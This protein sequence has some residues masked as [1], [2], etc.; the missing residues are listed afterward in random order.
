MPD[1]LSNI[2]ARY[3]GWEGSGGGLYK[4]GYEPAT[5][6]EMVL[7]STRE[8]VYSYCSGTIVFMTY[9]AINFEGQPEGEIAIRYGS[10]YVVKHVHVVDFQ[11]IVQVGNTIE[12]GELIGYTE[13]MG[14]GGFWEV[15]VSYLKGNNQYRAVPLY[16]F[17]DTASKAV[18]DQIAATLGV[19]WLHSLSESTSESWV[20]YVGTHEGWSDVSKAGLRSEIMNSYETVEEYCTAYGLSWILN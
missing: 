3:G 9:E 20:S 15:E 10:K 4:T 7:T 13:K 17:L 16:F 14:A 2:S 11:P 6:S 1:S 19:S 8:P 18:F 12:A 5:E